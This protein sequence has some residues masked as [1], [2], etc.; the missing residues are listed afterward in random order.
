ML[1][2]DTA[3]GLVTFYRLAFYY[4]WRLAEPDWLSVSAVA[5][6]Q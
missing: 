3:A 2:N 5:E 4:I 1:S 6:S